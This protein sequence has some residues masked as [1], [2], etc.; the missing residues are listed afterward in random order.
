MWNEITKWAKTHG[1]KI[2]RKDGSIH[3]CYLANPEVCGSASNI[4]DIATAI[5]N[6][7]SDY[8][9]VEYQKNYKLKNDS[10]SSHNKKA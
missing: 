1:Y 8:K 6:H 2:S 4:D 3:W 10:L 5:F 7:I 9:W